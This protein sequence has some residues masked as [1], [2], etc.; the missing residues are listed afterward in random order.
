MLSIL[1]TLTL[2]TDGL[3]PLEA[4]ERDQQQL[5]EKMAPSVVFIT[6]SGTLG[7][8]VVV[9]A[10]LVLTNA[11]V[12][13]KAQQVEVVLHDGRRSKGTVV[14]R[15]SDNI[16]LA[17]VS[18][19]FDDAPVAAVAMSSSLRVG[20]WVGAIGHGEG[21]VWSFNVGMVSNL[22]D[23]KSQRAVFQTQIPLNPGN[24]GGP[25]FDRRGTVVGIVV[26]GVSGANSINFGIDV[27]VAFRALPKLRTAMK[28]L[29]LF[30]PKGV[31][32][33]FDNQNVGS[34]P[35]VVVERPNKPTDAFAV[36]SGTMVRVRVMPDDREARLKLSSDAGR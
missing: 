36:I 23:G 17:L 12:V 7:S 4:I 10:G 15:G 1:L 16:D 18:I 14:E 21:S 11:H 25:I 5:F 27:E 30:A 28:S 35:V 31:P 20:S 2:A 19:P 33:F 32:I 8:G 24:S 13:G 34:G 6:Q 22:Y 9:G 26:S 3:S 29:T